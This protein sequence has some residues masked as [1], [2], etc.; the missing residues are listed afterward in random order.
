MVLGNTFHLFLSPGRGAHRRARRPARVHGLGR[1]DHHRLRR[2][3]GLLA[4][5]W[6]RRRRDQGPARQRRGPRRDPR[7]RRGRGPLSLLPRRRRALHGAGGV[8]G[9]SRRRSAPISPSSS[10]SARPTTRTSTTRPARP[11]GRIAGSIAAS[12]GTTERAPPGRRYSGS[13]RA[14]S[15]RSFG[16]SSAE[17]SARPRSTASRSAAR[18]AATRTRCGGAGPDRAAPAGGRAQAPARDRRARRPPQRHRA[19]AS[20][21]ST[22]PSPRA[23]DGTGWRLLPMPDDRFRMN[24]RSRELADGRRAAGG[25]LSL[26]GL[27]PPHPRLH[28]L[29]GPRRGAD[30]GTASHA[31]QPHLPGAPG[32]RSSRGDR[33]G[34]L[35]RVQAGRL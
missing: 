19:R 22:A 25:W 21:S 15:T 27:R 23:W 9:Q 20:T 2:L 35:R 16:A 5:P 24:V 28:P 11:S 6:E 13:S 31:P 4:R 1:R 3:P 17:R 30:G 10:T 34:A 12:S 18:S 33:G 26:S 29:P 14:E 7:D 8:D 32:R